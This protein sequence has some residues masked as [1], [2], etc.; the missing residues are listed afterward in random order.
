MYPELFKI[1]FTNLT[2]Y[3]YGAML[4]VGF[5]SAI[6]LIRILSRNITKDPNHI[7]NAALYALIAGIVGSRLFYV[8]HYYDRFED[9][10]LSV[11]AIWQGGLE[12]L[13]GVIAALSV[14]IFYMCYHKL[15]VRKYLDI[16]AIALMLALSFGRI[17]C[18]FRGCCYGKPADVP[19]AIRFPYGSDAYLSQIHPDPQRDRSDPQ[20]ELPEEYFGYYEKDSQIYTNLKPKQEL[21]AA[22]QDLVEHGQYRCLRVHPTQLYSSV[23][24]AILCVL[25]YLFWRRSRK[26]QA[27][28]NNKKLLTRDGC[29]F[30]LMLILYGIARFLLE[31]LR[32]DNPFEFDNLTVSQNIGVGMVSLGIVLMVIFEKLKFKPPK[33]QSFPS[34]Q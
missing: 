12:L 33:V 9:N 6:F 16:L 23:N 22:Q 28:E 10:L 18:F 21:T 4:V 29:T 7:T 24:G 27:V 19:W 8:V 32:D 3:T 20:L 30:A 15:P 2:V 14:L 31:F 34:K 1:P 13:G 11:F 25:L 17:G 5:L 26:S